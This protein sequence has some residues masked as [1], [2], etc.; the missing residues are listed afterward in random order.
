MER[1]NSFLNRGR[2]R[3]VALRTAFRIVD[4]NSSSLSTSQKITL[5][6]GIASAFIEGTIR[7]T[8]SQPL[9]LMSRI[10]TVFEKVRKPQR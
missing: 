5:Q 1:F 9:E 7:E 2:E 3:R 8:I 10:N 4:L 6:T